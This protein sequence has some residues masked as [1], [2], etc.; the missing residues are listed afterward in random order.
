MVSEHK[1]PSRWHELIAKKSRFLATS[2]LV[3]GLDYVVYLLLVKFVF[4]PVVANLFSYTAIMVLNFVLQRYFVFDMERN[5]RKTFA[6]AMAIS[7]GGLVISTILIHYLDQIAYL[8]ER[9]YALKAIVT[10]LLFFYNFYLKRY[11]FEKKFI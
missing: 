4:S 3:T 8:S 10:S 2:G 9:Q 11:A 5:I 7:T 1:Y 6:L